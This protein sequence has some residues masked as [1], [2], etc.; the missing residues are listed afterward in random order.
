MGSSDRF[1][2]LLAPLR[3]DPG[4]TGIFSDFDGTLAPIVD[5]PAAASPLPAA[6]DALHG[7]AGRLGRVAVVSG[8]PAAW[9]HEAFGHG[10]DLSGLYGLEQVAGDGAGE[11]VDAV[12]RLD[13][14]PLDPQV[15]AP[16][17]LH[18]L[19]VVLALDVDAAG[20]RDAGAGVVDVH[21]P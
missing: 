5:D 10:I 16:H 15:V 19:G 1:D 21:R 12:Q 2:D 3:A 11:V 9:L 4:T 17:L 18:Q 7:L 13:D 6:V 14:D 8:R 20:T